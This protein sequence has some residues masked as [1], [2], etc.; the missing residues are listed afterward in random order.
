MRKIACLNE[1]LLNNFILEQAFL[2][3]SG[4]FLTLISFLDRRYETCNH[5]KNVRIRC[6]SYGL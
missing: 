6:S 5:I 2:P 4:S 1:N 3:R